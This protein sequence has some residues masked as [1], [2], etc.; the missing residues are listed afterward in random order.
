MVEWQDGRISYGTG[1][2]KAAVKPSDRGQRPERAGKDLFSADWNDALN[3]TDD[4]G[5]RSAVPSV[6]FL[7]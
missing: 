6:L 4:P 5:S 1:Y 3:V 7:P 2:V